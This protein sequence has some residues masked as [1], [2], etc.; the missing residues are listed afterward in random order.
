MKEYNSGKHS[1]PTKKKLESSAIFFLIILISILVYI[2]SSKYESA[3]NRSMY[4]EIS[5]NID[6]IE[7]ETDDIVFEDMNQNIDNNTIININQTQTIKDDVPN[8][9]KKIINARRKNSDVIGWIKIENTVINYP[10]LQT[11]D[12]HYYLNYNYKKQ[13]S[14]YGAIFAKNECDI[15]NDNSNIIIYGHNMKDG[16][17][18]SQLLKYEDENFYKSHKTVK[19][20]NINEENEYIIVAVFKSRIFYQ[21]EKDAFKFYNYTKFKNE[22]EY[23]SFL[24][25]CKKEQ[26]YDTGVSA[27]YGEQL[28]TLITCENS[29][30]NGRMV[31]VAKKK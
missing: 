11:S 20:A 30:E 28:I 29:Q 22:E 15:Y 23:N 14:K 12:N 7:T 24:N 25:N 17:M 4:K 31:V 13:K 18:F 2:L 27:Q 6:E 3:K 16:Q 5:Q 8:S 19:L 10:V 9:V 26:L 1:K 21:D